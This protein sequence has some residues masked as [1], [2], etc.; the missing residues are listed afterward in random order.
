MATRKDIQVALDLI[1]RVN[2]MNDMLDVCSMVMQDKDPETGMKLRLV[3]EAESQI[4]GE[5][6]YKNATEIDLQEIAVRKCQNAKGY[7]VQ[8][9]AFLKKV[10]RQMIIDSLAALG[11]SLIDIEN[12]L[13]QMNSVATTVILGISSKNTKQ[14]IAEFSKEI[15]D[16]V[17]PLRLV[18]RTW[19]L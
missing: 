12:D 13:V 4:A 7:Y 16:N 5:T 1:N 3:D 14:A 11:L 17:E 6:Q 9:N 15:T 18:R 10:D 2:N 19:C 8:C